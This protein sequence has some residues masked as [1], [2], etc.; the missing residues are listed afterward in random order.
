MKKLNF[1]EKDE[2]LKNLEEMAEVWGIGPN[3]ALK[4]FNYGYR[5]VEDLKNRGA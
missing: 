2:K 5:G 4:L 1:L 3:V